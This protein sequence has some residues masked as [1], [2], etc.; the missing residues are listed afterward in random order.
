MIRCE[1]TDD[2]LVIGRP[3]EGVAAIA[4]GARIGGPR[5]GGRLSFPRCR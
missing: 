4:P 5:A 2:P 3:G 1:D